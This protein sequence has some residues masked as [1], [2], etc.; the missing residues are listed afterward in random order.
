MP[1]KLFKFGLC[2]IHN[3]LK[4][5]GLSFQTMTWKRF[6]SLNRKEAIKELSSRYENNLYLVHRILLEC[7]QNGWVYRV[8]SDIFPLLTH[9]EA[10][11]KYEELPNVHRLD[12]LFAFCKRD[13]LLYNVR[14]SCHPDQFN[15]LA[16]DKADAIERTIVELNHHAWFMTK[17]G[18]Y[19]DHRSPIN[20]HINCSYDE[21]S[22]IAERFLAN[23]QRLSDDVKTRLVVENEDKGIWNVTNL[24]NVFYNKTNIPITFDYLHHACNNDGV[25]EEEAFNLCYN[26]WKCRPLFHYC[27]SIPGE[28]NKRKHAEFATSIPDTYGKEVD[29]DFEFKGKDDAIFMAE[30]SLNGFQENIKV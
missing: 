20:I 17:M 15:V 27:E 13:A 6:C 23:F 1:Q 22:E 8:S 7:A 2:C 10:N 21:P 30:K 25:S 28:L 24:V 18:A 9:P 5:K 14:L 3:G 4:S 26:T 12:N 16:S 19:T 11:I 29:L